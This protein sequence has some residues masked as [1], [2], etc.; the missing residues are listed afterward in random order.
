VNEKQRAALRALCERC[1]ITFVEDNYKPVFDLPQGWV[2]G[3]AGTL[4]VGCDPEG[5]ISS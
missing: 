5:R 2:A 1:N 3:Y 4:Y